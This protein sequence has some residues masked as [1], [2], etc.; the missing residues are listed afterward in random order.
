MLG[1]AERLLAAT[2]YAVELYP[3]YGLSANKLRNIAAAGATPCCP[4]SGAN[5]SVKAVIIDIARC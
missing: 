5:S 1:A 3:T 2:G 4:A